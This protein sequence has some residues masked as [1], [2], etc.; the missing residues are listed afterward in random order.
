M[1]LREKV[2]A[3]PPKPI[4]SPDLETCKVVSAV[5][6]LIAPLVLRFILFEVMVNAL[7][8]V[9]SVLRELIVKLPVPA[10]FESELKIVVPF[11]VRLED[12]VI[13]SPAFTVNPCKEESVV[14]KITEDPEAVAFKV[15]SPN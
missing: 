11:V 13:P 14:P 3:P 1:L 9:L 10:L 12:S 15:S 4:V 7:L 6:E 5:P 8:V 2:P